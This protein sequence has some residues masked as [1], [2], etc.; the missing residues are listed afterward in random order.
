MAGKGKDKPENNSDLL[1]RIALLERE[2]ALLRKGIRSIHLNGETVKVPEPF[3]DIFQRAQETVGKYF[4]GIQIEPTKATIEIEGQRYILVRASALSI[5]FFEKLKDL[6]SDKGEKEAVEIGRNFLF[7]MAHVIGLQDAKAFHKVKNLKNPVEKLSAGP[8][9]FAYTGWAFVD[10]SPESNPSPDDNFL[11]KYDHPFSFEADS[12]V[13]AGKTSDFPVCIMNAGYSSGWCEASFG[14]PLTAVEV[15]CRAMGHDKCSFVMAPPHRIKDYLPGVS[16]IHDSNDVYSIPQFFERKQAEEAIKSSLAEKEVL[17]KEIHHRV[18]NNLQIISSLLKLQSS[19]FEHPQ[20]HKLI[21]ESQSRIKTM[22]IVHEKLY[23]S[24]LGWVDLF[25]YLSTVAESAG[26]SIT[27]PGVEI[28]FDLVPPGEPIRLKI[29]QAIPFGLIVN[30]IV[31]NSFKHAFTG[32]KKG[33]IGIHFSNG[34]EPGRM[35]LEIYDNGN[36]FPATQSDAYSSFG[37]ELIHMLA[38]QLDAQIRIDQRKGTKYWF[39]FPYAV[40]EE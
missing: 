34:D 39:H 6:Y 3:E 8:V 13:N 28:H 20:L 26:E 24:N 19:Y 40:P 37:L 2:N 5:D 18:K 33:E 1:L 11:L 21:L 32:K 10:I 27:P 12:W 23:Q 17:L 15:T 7:D 38:D 22:A 4:S 14:L 30:E 36:G 35:S 16:E 9:H 31:T 29:D 25:E